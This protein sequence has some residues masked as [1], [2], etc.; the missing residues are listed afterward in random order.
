[1]KIF[2]LIKLCEYEEA[3]KVRSMIDRILPKAEKRFYAEFDNKMEAKRESLRAAQREDIARL[4]E[5]LKGLQWKDRRRREK[6]ASLCVH[7][8]A[9][10]SHELIASMT[11]S[12]TPPPP[13]PFPQ[14]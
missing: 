14:G 11:N 12:Y 13:L 1:M 9:C 5:K 10:Y 4:E 8:R 3:R 6:E 2:R 7:F